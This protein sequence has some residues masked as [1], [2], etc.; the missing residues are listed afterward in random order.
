[1]AS[2]IQLV[3]T[4]TAVTA[5]INGM[6][7]GPGPGAATQLAQVQAVALQQVNAFPNAV[8]LNCIVQCN[9]D[10]ESSAIHITVQPA[11]AGPDGIFMMCQATQGGT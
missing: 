6:T 2:E 9:K 4:P 10:V 7:P 11:K 1:M 5:A 3:G 8:K